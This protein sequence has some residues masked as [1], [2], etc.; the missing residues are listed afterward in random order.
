[1][2]ERDEERKKKR[3]EKEDESDEWLPFADEEEAGG[4]WKI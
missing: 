3:M 4:G 2:V 1:V